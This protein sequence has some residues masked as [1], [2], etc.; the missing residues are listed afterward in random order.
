MLEL[1]LHRG[2]GVRKLGVDLGRELCDEAAQL[3]HRLL[4]VAA[5]LAQ[6][7]G[8][9]AQLRRLCLGQRVHRAD[10]LA[11][12]A[13]ALQAL[14]QRG[15]LR[16]VG[17][18]REAGLVELLAD[19]LELRGKVGAAVLQA[20]QRHLHGRAP[21]GGLLQT[22][23]QPRLLLGKLAKAAPVQGGVRRAL[24][25]QGGDARAA[26]RA[27]RRHARRQR[28]THGAHARQFGKA[29]LE[30]RQARLV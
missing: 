11:A 8:A 10:A 5:L 24:V 2:E 1:L 3:V 9:L 21:L 4:Q 29:R 28:L 16:F 20:S 19:L 26:V 7:G 12:P 15:R 13:E 25:V 6:E 30:L 27:Q 18:R 14:A 17:G 22:T 23:A